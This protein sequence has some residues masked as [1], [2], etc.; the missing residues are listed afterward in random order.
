[1]RWHSWLTEKGVVQQQPHSHYSWAVW[2]K[3]ISP[4][5]LP[6]L[7]PSPPLPQG[8]SPDVQNINQQTPLHLVVE[9]RNIQIFIR[10]ASLGG[11]P[12]AHVHMEGMKCR[13]LYLNLLGVNALFVNLR[14][15]LLRI[16]SRHQFSSPEKTGSHCGI[17]T[18]V[19]PFT[20][21]NA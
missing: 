5:L 1:M 3:C 6:S 8:A 21:R 18:H 14:P 20:R 2:Q 7:S 13:V 15:L 10:L 19:H 16:R 9:R 12:Q 17:R 11:G 4:P